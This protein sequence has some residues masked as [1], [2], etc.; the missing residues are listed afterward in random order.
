MRFPNKKSLGINGEHKALGRELDNAE[1]KGYTIKALSEIEKNLDS[2]GA[3]CL[4]NK[5]RL[6]V[7]KGQ[8]MLRATLISGL[9][10]GSSLLLVNLDKI[11][12]FLKALGG[13]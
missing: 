13:A 1:F 6:D 9:I 5:S 11:F 2:L 8:A 10:A 12:L 3:I 4:D 7:I